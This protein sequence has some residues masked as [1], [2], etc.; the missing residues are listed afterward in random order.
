ME[1]SKADWQLFREKLPE[2]QENYMDR[3]IQEY[4]FL[5]NEEKASSEKFWELEKRINSDKRSPGV[6]V[7]YRKSDVLS[8]LLGLI[9]DG[10]ICFDDLIQ[11]SDDLRDTVKIIADR[12]LF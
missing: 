7:Q 12:N 8:I 6:S 4:V 9:R 2:W 11:F 10:V 1:I 5:L 3:L